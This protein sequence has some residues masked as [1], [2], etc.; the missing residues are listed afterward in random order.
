MLV[1]LFHELYKGYTRYV[2]ENL[3]FSHF[4][5]FRILIERFS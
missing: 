4:H 5:F 1:L 3:G 2:S